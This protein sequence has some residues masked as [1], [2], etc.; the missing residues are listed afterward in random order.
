L[1]R[2][3]ITGAAVRALVPAWST[4]RVT[5][6][7]LVT[8]EAAQPLLDQIKRSCAGKRCLY[9]LRIRDDDAEHMRLDHIQ[10]RF[11]DAV[12]HGSGLA[13]A[14]LNKV[15]PSTVLYVGCS[16]DLSVRLR[17]HLGF[18][19]NRTYA[20]RLNK[21]MPACPMDLVVAAYDPS[22]SNDAILLLEETLWRDLKPM[23]GRPGSAR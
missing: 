12:D 20:L 4:F 11:A 5:P 15:D 6:D 19:P 23:F 8:L 17:Q 10:D 14:R 9:V 13:F 21:W 2:L 7:H 22:A 3:D 18:G 1:E 16:S